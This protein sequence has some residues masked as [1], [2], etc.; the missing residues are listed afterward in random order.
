VVETLRAARCLL[1]PAAATAAPLLVVVSDRLRRTVKCLLA[2]ACGLPCLHFHWLDECRRAG[3]RA[4]L[5]PFSL[6]TA[7][8]AASSLSSSPSR[9]LS[10]LGRSLCLLGSSRFLRDWTTL[11]EAAGGTLDAPPDSTVSS[12]GRGRSG[13]G[14]RQRQQHKLPACS[15]SSSKRPCPQHAVAASCLL[16]VERGPDDLPDCLRRVQP[17]FDVVQVSWLTDCLLHNRL[18]PM[19]AVE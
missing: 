18:L 13:G 7:A 16:V 12:R 9:I 6:H 10:G 17:R 11:V 19:T 1:P 8:V 14:Q 3:R 15:S 5:R 2:A 4:E